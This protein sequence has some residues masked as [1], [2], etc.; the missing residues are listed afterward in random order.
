MRDD[1]NI[2]IIPKKHEHRG[3]ALSTIRVSGL[4][5]RMESCFTEGTDLIVAL[6]DHGLSVLQE[7][8]SKQEIWF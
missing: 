8:K 1:K 2:D 4:F 5:L 3:S 6:S 7:A